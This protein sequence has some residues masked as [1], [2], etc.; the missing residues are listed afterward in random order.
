MT[1]LFTYN[2]MIGNFFLIFNLINFSKALSDV[3]TGSYPLPLSLL[4]T[5]KV[6]LS[7]EK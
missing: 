4:D 5:L 7:F 1:K 2:L 3:V 6:L